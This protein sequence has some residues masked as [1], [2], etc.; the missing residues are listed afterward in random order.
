M[1]DPDADAR[2]DRRAFTQLSA[3]GLAF[4]AGIG[5]RSNA[6]AKPADTATAAAFTAL[7]DKPLTIGILIFPDMDQIDF[8]GPF[9]VLSRLPNARIV[10]IGSQKGPFKDHLGL[11]LTPDCDVAG[12][13]ELDVLQVAGGPGQEAMMDREPVLALIRNHAAAGK[14]LFSVCTGALI[15][16]AAGVLRGRRA[17]THWAA[18]DLLPYFGAIPVR[19]RVVVDGN[20]VS[21]AGVTAGLDGAFRVAALLR[22]EAV[23]E[24]IQLDIQYAPEP[25]FHAGLPG[26]APSDVLAA[27]EAKYRPLTQ[28]RLQTAKAIWSRLGLNNS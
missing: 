2:L 25:P 24:R 12:A 11:M 27:V 26:T 10:V 23:A 4:G 16:G 21:A 13:P 20:L 7:R 1:T 18:F 6:S 3:A 28:A 9:E 5:S 8:T 15:C 22:G 14:P 19:Q 17:T